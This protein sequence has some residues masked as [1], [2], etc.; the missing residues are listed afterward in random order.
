MHGFIKL[1]HSNKGDIM[2]RLVGQVDLQPPRRST[3]HRAAGPSSAAVITVDVIRADVDSIGWTE[4]P[5]GSVASF[6]ASPGDAP[7]EP[8][9]PDPRPADFVL[10]GRRARSKRRRSSAYGHKPDDGNSSVEEEED[11][12]WLPPPSTP[13]RWMRSPTPPPPPPSPPHVTP[14]PPPPPHETALPRPAPHALA[15]PPPPPPY[16][17]QPTLALLPPRPLHFGAPL[18]VPWL[19]WGL[20]LPSVPLPPLPCPGTATFTQHPP[21]GQPPFW[22]PPTVPPCYPAP[23]WGAP[24]ALQ[25]P[26][27]FWGGQPPP[28]PQPPPPHWGYIRSPSAPALQQPPPPTMQLQQQ[29]PLHLQP[30]VC[31]GRSVF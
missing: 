16:C 2:L 25:P 3:L 31:W 8:V 9:E 23:F 14:S 5:I 11:E 13:P 19:S 20:P 15:P 30:G 21:P 22:N 18:T 7:P 1:H 26:Q 27:Q 12:E 24:S 6:T 4:C 29:S 10:V 28:Q 17:G